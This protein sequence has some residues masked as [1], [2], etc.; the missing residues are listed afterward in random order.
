[1][2]LGVNRGLQDVISAGDGPESDG[3]VG[4]YGDEERLPSADED[5]GG[6]TLVES[7]VQ[8]SGLHCSVPLLP[9]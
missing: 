8:T 4:Q 7:G 3:S 9:F 1:M 6:L 2:R 5:V